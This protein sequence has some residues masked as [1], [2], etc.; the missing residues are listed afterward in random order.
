M[1][2]ADEANF[3]AEFLAI[4]RVQDKTLQSQLNYDAKP[5]SGLK[6]GASLSSSKAASSV[7]AA[8][9]GTYD[10]SILFNFFFKK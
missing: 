8:N 4:G 3:L 10:Y 2:A 6:A 1:I 9:E 7:L 5:R